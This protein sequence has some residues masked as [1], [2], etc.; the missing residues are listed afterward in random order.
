[1]AHWAGEPPYPYA[2][3]FRPKARTVTAWVL[4]T[5]TPAG[6]VNVPTDKATA[7]QLVEAGCSWSYLYAPRNGRPHT[8]VILTDPLP[9][10]RQDR[11]QRVLNA[12]A[13]R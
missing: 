6:V 10:A 13:A 11:L 7:D 3:P 2:L 12:R 4:C 9:T 1:M 5:R 8:V